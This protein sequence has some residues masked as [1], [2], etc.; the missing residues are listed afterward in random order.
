[1]DYQP[2]PELVETPLADVKLGFAGTLDF[3]GRCKGIKNKV[4]CDLKTGIA[5]AIDEQLA[6]YEHLVRVNTGYR[7]LIDRY[8]LHVSEGGYEFYKVGTPTDFQRFRLRLALWKMER[9]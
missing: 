8:H 5:G 7:R 4:L 1:M 9:G 2:V 6:A 3:L